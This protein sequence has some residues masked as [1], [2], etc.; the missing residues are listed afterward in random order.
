MIE[1][2]RMDEE[3]RKDA[4]DVIESV[5][6]GISWDSVGGRRRIRNDR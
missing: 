4:L 6:H 3:L 5:W 2:E 1:C